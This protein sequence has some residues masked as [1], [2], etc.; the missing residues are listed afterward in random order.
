MKMQGWK[1]GDENGIELK[2][3]TI[4]NDAQTIYASSKKKVIEKVEY[5]IKIVG[6]ERV[7]IASPD[8]VN[9]PI[10]TQKTFGEIKNEIEEK[11]S[12]RREY[13][14]DDYA[15][16]DIRLLQEDEDNEDDGKEI[17]E[18]TKITH[19]MTVYV[20][21][22]YKN[23]RLKGRALQGV[24]GEAPRGRIFL[25]KEIEI[26]EKDAFKDCDSLVAVDF[27]PNLR[28]IKGD[29][30]IAGHSNGGAF[31]NCTNLKSVNFAGC[32]KLHTIGRHTF[33]GCKKL[34]KV[35]LSACT[36]LQKIGDGAF[37]KYDVLESVNLG[38]CGE[39]HTIELMAFFLCT[40]LENVNFSVC[41]KLEKIDTMAFFGCVALKTL[42]LKDCA[43]LKTIGR[44]VV[45]RSGLE[46]F[47]V[48]SCI[49]MK[50]ITIATF[51]GFEQKVKLPSSITKIEKRA[52]S[53]LEEAMNGLH[54]MPA[55]VLVPNE[56][57]KQLVI[58]A[59]YPPDRIKMYQ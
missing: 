2:D 16:Y 31:F 12:F 56:T 28:E 8:Y 27:S 55:E 44:H 26:I 47:D 7:K 24:S 19:D 52:F 35:D 1:T 36:K 17:L 53:K 40:K 42:D 45:S 41:T 10:A 4:F 58:S 54:Q 21:T 37:E 48:S 25:P 20:R 3:E 50:V 6:D 39:L 18:N 5:R 59:G 32:D 51:G 9:V 13:S 43:E 49:K 57:I 14:S 46:V 30:T 34:E 29:D 11:V 15:I 38:G 22:N 33:S 23:F